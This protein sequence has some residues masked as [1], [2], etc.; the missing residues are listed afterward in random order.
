MI[1]M[2]G[3]LSCGPE[4]NNPSLISNTPYK[5][6][7]MCKSPAKHYAIVVLFEVHIVLHIVIVGEEIIS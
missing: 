2:K 4:E 6:P 7:N 3:V 1:S 5:D